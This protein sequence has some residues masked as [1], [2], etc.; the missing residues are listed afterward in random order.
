MKS[1][2][3]LLW[4][5]Q[6]IFK[7]LSLCWSKW[8][9]ITRSDIQ[10]D[11]SVS[12]SMAFSTHF[13]KR[14]M[15]ALQWSYQKHFGQWWVILESSTLVE[16][17][18]ILHTPGHAVKCQGQA[19]AVGPSKDLSEQLHIHIC[20]SHHISIPG[21]NNTAKTQSQCGNSVSHHERHC[22]HAQE[23]DGMKNKPQENKI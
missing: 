3:Y 7:G 8:A 17:N 15:G 1:C 16:N 20:P 9:H 23:T 10:T 4:T 2:K 13:P 18:C 11:G 21:P 14:S 5:W 19:P 12:K 6:M 22:T